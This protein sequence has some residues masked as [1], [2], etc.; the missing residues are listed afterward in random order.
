VYQRVKYEERMPELLAAADL[1]VSRSGG[2][3]AEIAVV[4]RA[5]IL[6][7]L[8]IAP[9]DHQAANAKVLVDAGAAI[10]LRD[11]EVTV[12]R[13]AS[14]IEALLADGGALDRMGDAARTVAHPDAAARVADLVI[15]HAKRRGT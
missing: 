15:Q 3:V 4:G 12:E 2:S 1:V 14:E 8:P 13:L 9:Y 11:P 7:P 6:V 10:M 5:S